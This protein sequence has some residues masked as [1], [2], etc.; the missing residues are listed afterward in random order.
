M[1]YNNISKYG[2]PL[3]FETLFILAFFMTNYVYPVFLYRDMPYFSLFRLNFSE[4]IMS[5][6]TA[7]ATVG[8]CAYN[9]GQYCSNFEVHLEKRKWRLKKVTKLDLF[10]LSIFFLDFFVHNISALQT[11]FTGGSHSSFV[12]IFSIY[13]V[14]KMFYNNISF[15]DIF[16]KNIFPWALIIAFILISLIIGN[17]GDPLYILM[18]AAICYSLYIKRINTPKFV[19]MLV[20]GLLVFFLVGSIRVSS[21][22]ANQVDS[23]TSRLASVDAVDNYF[24]YGEQMIINARSLYVLVDRADNKGFNYGKTWLGSVCSVFPFM[25][26]LVMKTFNIPPEDFSTTELTTYLEF[27]QDNDKAF[28]LGT[29]VIGDIYICFGIIGVMLF[30]FLGG[31]F[32]Q[33]MYVGSLNENIYN[34]L[35]Y[36]CL[37]TLSVYYTRAVYLSPLRTIA[38]TY[39]LLH[40]NLIKYGKKNN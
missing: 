5:K 1:L 26:G 9:I 10:L 38:W 12:T 21:R 4:S 37:F 35:I 8:I 6:A 31:R 27:G 18:A 36:C 14:F 32:V 39:L 24:M 19:S 15:V 7:V 28:G 11:G 17:R 33:T 13:L 23:I 2:T 34:A 16:L 29:N 3:L 22:D 20:V 30:M 40:I 25:Q